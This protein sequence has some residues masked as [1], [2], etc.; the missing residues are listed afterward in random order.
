MFR[1]KASGVTLLELL[2]AIAVLGIIT[3]IAYPAYKDYLLEAQIEIAKGDIANIDQLL[4]RYRLNHSS[5]PETLD[6]IPGIPL[7]PWDNPYQYLNIETAKGKGKQRKDHNL[8]PINSDYDLYSMGPD[9]RSVSPLTASHSRDD[10]VRA[11][12]GAYIGPASE[13]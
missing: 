8:V 9:G 10:I 2:I 12:D 13:Y 6:E 11:N 1:V 7:D 5:N 4:F 3:A